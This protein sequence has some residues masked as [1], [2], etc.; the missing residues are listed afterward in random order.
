M[1]LRKAVQRFIQQ[2]KGSA[3]VETALILPVV[4]L[5]GFFCV[6]IYR[7]HL[8]RTQLEQLAGSIGITISVQEKL[9]AAGLNVLYKQLMPDSGRFQMI[10]TNVSMPSKQIWWTLQ[11]GDADV[12]Q[13]QPQLGA[14]YSDDLPDQDAVQNQN[15]DDAAESDDHSVVVVHL[16]EDVNNLHIE[17]LLVPSKFETTSINRAA[18]KE[19]DLDDALLGE[20]VGAIQEEKEE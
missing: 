13:N 8:A 1:T 7:L 2:E 9:E 5:I 19:I 11:R 17:R 3:V 4:L 14:Y 18:Y 20:A 16:C 12:C 6:D 15:G 10:V